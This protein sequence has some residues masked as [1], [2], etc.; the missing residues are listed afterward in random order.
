HRFLWR[1]CKRGSGRGVEH[2]ACKRRI[3]RKRSA[4]KETVDRDWLSEPAEGERS[5]KPIL[6]FLAIR[7][8][9]ASN[10]AA[11]S[12]CSYLVGVVFDFNQDE[13]AIAAVFLVKREHR[14]GGRTGAG[15]AIKNDSILIRDNLQNT[16]YQSGGLGCIEH[17][18]AIE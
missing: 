6:C 9:D 10:C 18:L 8:R 17:Y 15:E 3:V 1:L 12:L 16:A 13:F 14:L 2:V 11:N 5:A 7:G 4:F